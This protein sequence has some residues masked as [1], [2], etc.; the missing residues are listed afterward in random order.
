M[1]ELKTK[2]TK[3]SVSAFVAAIDDEGVRR[4]CRQLV[5]IMGQATRSRPKMWGKSIAGF[6]RYRYQYASGRSGEWFLTGFAPRKRDLTL[7]LTSG[8]D[9]SGTLLKA[10][11]K[12]KTGRGCLYLKSLDEVH[13][14]TLRKLIVQSTRRMAKANA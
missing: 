7:Y 12:H 14:P 8:F 1:A 10:P 13:L 5:K 9:G 2:P 4:D 11:G 6:G 3:R